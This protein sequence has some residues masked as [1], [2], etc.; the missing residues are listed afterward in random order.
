MPGASLRARVWTVVGVGVFA[1]L[2]EVALTFV[3]AYDQ[4]LGRGERL[5]YSASAL[6]CWV[7]VVFVGHIVGRV[8][9]RL[10]LK[11]MTRAA[12]GGVAGGVVFGVLAWESAGGRRVESYR[13]V[14]SLGA[15]LFCG[16]AIRRLLIR[17]QGGTWEFRLAPLLLAATGLLAADAW[18]LHRLYPGFHL[19]L[20]LAALG[21]Y[22]AASFAGDSGP[23]VAR[24]T[25]L[26]LGV[27]L[28]T[29]A[30]TAVV[31]FGRTGNGRF[32]AERYAAL[33]GKVLLSFPAEAEE[34]PSVEDPSADTL[35]LRG[36]AS[37]GP[38][39]RERDVLLISVDAL[40]AD[41]VTSVRMPNLAQLADRGV[42][43][44]RAYTPTPHTSYA[45]SSLLTG[46]FV[47]PVMALPGEAREHPSLAG[48]LRDYGYRT[49]A[50]YP[51][52]IFF[53]D[54]AR[55]GTLASD[56]F[57]FEYRKTMF[58]P[59]AARVA[60]LRRYLDELEGGTDRRVFAWVHLFEP[61]EPYDPPEEFRR[62]ES[63][64]Q[65]YD[66]EV[67]A[68]DAAIGDLVRVF[69]QERPDGVVVITADHGE[70]FGEHGGYH[71][72]TTLYEEQVAVPLIWNAEG[73]QPR[74]VSA[75]AELVDIATTVLSALGIP[76]DARMRGDDLGGLLL[77]ED[78]QAPAYAFADVGEE[79]MAADSRY[80]LICGPRT[81]CQLYDLEADP[82]ERQNIVESEPEVAARL[83]GAL[84]TFAAS[85]PEVEAMSLGDDGA[86][87]PALA[88]AELGESDGA[89]LQLLLG[90][91]RTE[92][93]QAAARLLGVSGYEPALATLLRMDRDGEDPGVRVEALLASASLGDGAALTRV[94]A[95]CGEANTDDHWRRRAALALAERGRVVVEALIQIVR[96]DTASEDERRRAVVALG[97]SRNDRDALT[98]LI[99]ALDEVNLRLSALEALRSFSSLSLR[100]EVARRFATE[101]YLGARTLEAELL[102]EQHDSRARALIARWLG[103][104]EPMP[105]GVRLLEG[106]GRRLSGEGWS[107]TESRCDVG[108][109]AS[110]EAGAANEQAVFWVEGPGR[111][112]VGDQVFAL[113]E[114][115]HQVS[116]RELP[117]EPT[118]LAF[119][120]AGGLLGVA[121]V[122][123]T[124]ELPAPEPEPWQEDE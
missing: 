19:A 12:I 10:V 67:A 94:A 84:R 32:V 79:R 66:G 75:P 123:R 61:H 58:A 73:L 64:R 108:A 55:F 40:R 21:L 9:A 25:A 97:S 7:G 105:Q 34:E 37:S 11:P 86:W 6:A 13:I 47:R 26:L 121:I 17:W 116:V 39:W 63:A 87:P 90:S 103:T 50:F 33:T 74:R 3:R 41:A 122:P 111:L 65:R 2:T 36:E 53:V 88:Q 92:V 124:D 70:E 43:F 60:Q 62:G 24:S 96:D 4:F 20:V 101:R 85:I 114:E 80:K 81:A 29:L 69:R 89:A 98:A 48:L 15:A 115:A 49:A 109:D 68:A 95:M 117:T 35:A 107:C 72:G 77:H 99:A 76:L 22:C 28:T 45:L 42:V 18:V 44:E 119:E 71:H 23:W 113:S 16:W 78:A 100:N 46:K 14:V 91:Q 106:L 5:L 30:L 82:G 110:I 118:R 104:P 38:D 27:G 57:D 112:W 83:R 51:P 1:A 102:V 59:A 93:R 8:S 31:A 56:G 54:A 52:A 120:G